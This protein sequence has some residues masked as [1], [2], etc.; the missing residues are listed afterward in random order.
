MKMRKIRYVQLGLILAFTLIVGTCLPP[1][2][3]RI[4]ERSLL[5]QEAVEEAEVVSV[6][7]TERMEKKEP[8]E[9]FLFSAAAGGGIYR[10][11]C[12]GRGKPEC[13]HGPGS[14]GNGTGAFVGTGDAGGLQRGYGGFLRLV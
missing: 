14:A 9:K 13:G 2:I 5:D 1:F 4:Q 6:S 7:R 12:G 11:R 10:I 8:M 3:S